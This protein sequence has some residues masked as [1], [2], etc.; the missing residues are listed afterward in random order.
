MGM[1]DT[2]K[3]EYPLPGAP[4]GG[5]FQTKSF[6]DGYVGGFMDD[7]TL[8]KEGKLIHHKCDYEAVPEK[9]RPY[10]GKPEWDKN[11]LLQVCGML[12][13]INEEDVEMD[14]HGHINMHASV[15]N[16]VSGTW[17]EYNVKFTDGVVESVERIY[18]EF[19]K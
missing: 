13:P 7:Y 17:F 19:G 5:D 18:R 11:P 8:T 12:R 16:T 6:G 10:Y 15:G 3:C 14:Y 1:F 2:I 4:D 9:E